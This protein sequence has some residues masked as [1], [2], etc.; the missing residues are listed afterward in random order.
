[1]LV[2]RNVDVVMPGIS[3]DGVAVNGPTSTGIAVFG[4]TVGV[5]AYAND[6]GR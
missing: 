2:P 6:A 4:T 1:L 3:W 5:T